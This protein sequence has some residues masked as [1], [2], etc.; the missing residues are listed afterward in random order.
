MMK[1][2][3][4]RIVGVIPSRYGSTRF[5]GKPLV[6]IHGKPLIV[7][8]VEQARKA[9]ILDKVIVATDDDRIA[10]TVRAIGCDV[11]MTSPDCATG[12][13]RIAEAIGDDPWDIIIN[14]Q[15]DEPFIDPRVIDAVGRALAE[16]P[17]CGVATAMTPIRSLEDFQSPHVVKAVSDPQGRAVYFSRSPI[18]SPARLSDQDIKA[19]DFKWGMKH[20]GL[21]AYR[22]DILLAYTKWPQTPLEKR[23]CLEQLRLLERGI[24]IRLVEVEHDSIGVDTPEELKRLEMMPLS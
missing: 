11:A 20:L 8:V 7:R 2:S 12:S 17:E 10:D 23:E 5:P 4:V 14:I 9:E 18:P 6:Q 15:G 24:K 1:K 3:D 16:D 21:Y 22:R 19:P 13:D